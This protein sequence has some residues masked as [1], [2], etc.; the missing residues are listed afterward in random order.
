M[1][2]TWQQM[3]DLPQRDTFAASKWT[4]LH[5]TATHARKTNNILLF[6][7]ISPFKQNKGITRQRKETKQAILP[8]MIR[9]IALPLLRDFVLKQKL[10]YE[11]KKLLFS[12]DTGSQP[13]LL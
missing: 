8:L 6:F 1:M 4:T 2:K 5:K 3:R 11:S 13:A 7:N 9:P 10:D 12:E